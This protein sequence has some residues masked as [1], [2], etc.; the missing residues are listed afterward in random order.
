MTIEATGS[1]E[2]LEALLRILEPFGIR[3]L[4]QSGRG[5]DRPRRPFHHRPFVAVGIAQPDVPNHVRVTTSPT[6]GARRG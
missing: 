6:E 3:E 4:V 2:K 5:S 1:S